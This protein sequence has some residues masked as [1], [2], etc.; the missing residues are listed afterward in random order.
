[1]SYLAWQRFVRCVR[2]LAWQRFCEHCEAPSLAEVC[3]LCEVPSL[4]EVCELY[5]CEIL[6]V[7]WQRYGG[8]THFVRYLALDVS[9][10]RYLAWRR[11]YNRVRY[12]L[13]EVL[14]P[15]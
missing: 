1:M 13:A 7:T 15:C 8:P 4:A 6:T 11:Y 14:Q 3:E 12:T 10:D 5:E 9:C 2:Y